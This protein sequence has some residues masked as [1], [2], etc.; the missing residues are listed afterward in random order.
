M[1]VRRPVRKSML[2]CAGES[3]FKIR[4]WKIR[5]GRDFLSRFDDEIL[6]RFLSMKPPRRKNPLVTPRSER[7]FHLVYSEV[8]IF[9]ENNERK[10]P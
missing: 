3:P 1:A 8:S 4:G 10:L 7:D 6:L 9:T 2:S 5:L